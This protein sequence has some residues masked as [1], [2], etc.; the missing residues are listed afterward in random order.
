VTAAVAVAHR[1]DPY[2]ARENTLPSVRSALLKGAGAVEVD[3]KTTRDGVPVLLHD[4]TLERLW[5]VREAV[6]DLTAKEV[7]ECTLGGVPTLA[8][9]FAELRSH[10]GAGRMMLDLTA[11]DQVA[12][13][14]AA[15]ADAGVGDRVYYCGGMGALRTLRGL[16]PDAEI[17]MT[18]KSVARPPQP[19]L[20]EL[21]P[22][23]INLRFGVAD[24][25]VVLWAHDRG[26]LVG[27]WTAD[28]Q[29]NMS[30]LLDLGVDAIT[31]NR[32]GTLQRLLAA[33][34]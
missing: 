9:A 33:R 8:D 7:D 10:P 30:R 1:G 20:D 5:N 23:W 15:V 25:P 19:L 4:D 13:T 11:A 2:V 16:D 31:T 18:W 22:R 6:G 3:I 24:R 17:A 32:L 27:A 12:A 29:R 26:L 28:W 14:L 21:R 34:R